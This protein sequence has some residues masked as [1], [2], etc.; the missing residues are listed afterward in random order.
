MDL[1]IDGRQMRQQ[2]F[3]LLRPHGAQKFIPKVQLLIIHVHP[4]ISD[5][6]ALAAGEPTI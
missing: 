1:E 3:P 2:Q 5:N 4:R 6:A